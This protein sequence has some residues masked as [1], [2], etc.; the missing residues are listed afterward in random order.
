MEKDSGGGFEPNGSATAFVVLTIVAQVVDRAWT[1]MEMVGSELLSLAFTVAV[2]YP[3]FVAQRSA[4]V[5]CGDP[6]GDTNATFTLSNYLWCIPCLLLW[7]GVGVAI[8]ES[9][10]SLN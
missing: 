10:F 2:A 4:N 1:G 7:A 8:Y 5:A 6:D 3:L 9:T